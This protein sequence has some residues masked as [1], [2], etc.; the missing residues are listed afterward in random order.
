VAVAVAAEER[1]NTRIYA[2]QPPTKKRVKK[3]PPKAYPL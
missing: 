3:N 2:F 1:F